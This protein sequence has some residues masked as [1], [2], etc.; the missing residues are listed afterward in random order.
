MGRMAR[1]VL[2]RL[3]PVFWL[4]AVAL[5]VLLAV[6]PRWSAET[7]RTLVG[8][9]VLATGAGIAGSACGAIE[10]TH[11]ASI[12]MLIGALLDDRPTPGP[13]SRHCRPAA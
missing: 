7:A 10:S 1:S 8:M 9:L 3:S 6:D 11:T 4:A 2:S 5:A 13:R 12:D